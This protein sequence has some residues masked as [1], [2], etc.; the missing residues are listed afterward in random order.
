M[1]TKDIR[2]FQTVFDQLCLKIIDYN[3]TLRDD[4]SNFFKNY[5]NS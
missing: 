3:D 4:L 5:K 2:A 1:L